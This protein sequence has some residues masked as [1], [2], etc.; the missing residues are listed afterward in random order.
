MSEKIKNIYF[1]DQWK[2]YVNSSLK[3]FEAINIHGSY[4]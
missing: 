1:S 3:H 4:K 2:I